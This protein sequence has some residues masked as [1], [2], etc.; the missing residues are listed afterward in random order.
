MT[1]GCTLAQWQTNSQCAHAVSSSPTGPFLRVDVALPV[2]CHLPQAS[3]VR[4]G[5]GGGADLWALFHAGLG[6]EGGALNCSAG[7]PPVAASAGT[8]AGV[9][10]APS[11]ILHVSNSPYGPWE[12][13]LQPLPDCWTPSQMRL[14]NG[15]GWLMVCG[16]QSLFAAPNITGP[17]RHVV[18]IKVGNTPG[19]FEDPFLFA[20]PR[21][22]LH[23]F[24]H[25]YTMSCETPACEPVAISGHSFSRDGL[26][27]TSSSTQP[28]FNL[29]NVSDGSVVRMSTRERPKLRVHAR[30][31][32]LL[33]R[34]PESRL[35]RARAACKRLVA[36]RTRRAATRARCI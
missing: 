13:V 28:Y 17:W 23:V 5:G 2:W 14:A 25:T 24:F 1:E 31:P 19:T 26:S 22:N 34:A 20:D 12:P 15:S 11:S 29:V 27:W 4:G 32:A 7:L 10:A 18:D 30:A 35:P 8:S 21:G 36:L 33:R 16:S 3:V 6:S 9:T